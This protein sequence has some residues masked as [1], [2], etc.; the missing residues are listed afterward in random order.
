MFTVIETIQFQ[1]LVD[2]YL[3]EDSFTEFKTHLANHPEAGD[4]IPGSGGVRKIR[5]RRAGMGKSGGVRIIYFARL[6]LGELVLLTIYA[7]AKFD[8]IP[9][10]IARKMKE[11]YENP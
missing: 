7:K 8:N 1:E 5:W 4:V 9:P 10:K 6:K 3:D 2:L 11:A